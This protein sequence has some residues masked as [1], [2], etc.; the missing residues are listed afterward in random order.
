M[1]NLPILFLHGYESSGQGFKGQFLRKQF[2]DIHT[3]TLT[4]EMDSRLAQVDPIFQQQDSWVLIGSSFGG[5]MATLLAIRYPQKVSRL[6]LMAPALIPPFYT[7]MDRVVHVDCPTVIIHGI[8]DEVVSFDQVKPIA[9]GLYTDLRYIAVADDHR[10]HRTTKELPWQ[11][12][13]YGDYN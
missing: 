4:G 10:L 1:S 13:V 8:G 12:L 9:E 7:G 3:P 2:P 5:L 6:I 11:E